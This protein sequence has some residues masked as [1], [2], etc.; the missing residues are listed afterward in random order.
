[1][2]A[3]LR[4]KSVIDP[5]EG[6]GAL[7]LGMKRAEVR[8]LLGAGEGDGKQERFC[9]GQ[10]L[11]EYRAGRVVFIEASAGGSIQPEL[12]GKS[13]FRTPAG[14]LF[15]LLRRRGHVAREEEPGTLYVFPE[16]RVA[17]W[18]EDDPESLRQELE[19]LDLTDPGQRATRRILAADIRRYEKF[20]T[21]ATFVK[22]YQRRRQRQPRKA[23]APAPSF[24]PLLEGAMAM[25]RNRG[26]K[27]DVRSVLESIVARRSDWKAAVVKEAERQL[28]AL[29]KAT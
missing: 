15:A 25:T 22:G 4:G 10:I 7:R 3:S 21:V 14:E 23:P 17:V 5:G 18:R 28:E 9:R 1:M 24:S 20:Q 8:E 16:L 2:K 19:N 27:P 11:V 13:V 12:F 26:G 6:L 29:G